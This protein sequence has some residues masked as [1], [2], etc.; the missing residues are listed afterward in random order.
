MTRPELELTWPWSAL[1]APPPCAVVVP[2]GSG[3]GGRGRRE[4]PKA[5]DFPQENAGSSVPLLPSAQAPS[6]WSRGLWLLPRSLHLLSQALGLSWSLGLAAAGVCSG[7]SSG[8][9]SLGRR[10]VAV[11]SHPAHSGAPLPHICR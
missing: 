7:S 1:A 11:N 10:T 9:P 5:L 6:S 3:G 2:R 8:S 4:G